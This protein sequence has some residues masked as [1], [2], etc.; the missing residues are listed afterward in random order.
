MSASNEASRNHYGAHQRLTEQDTG[1]KNTWTLPKLLLELGL[2]W[3]LKSTASRAELLGILVKSS[4]HFGIHV[5]WT[6]YIGP[7]LLRP[8]KGTIYTTL[9]ERCIEWIRDIE[10]IIARGRHREYLRRC[11][12]IVGGTGQPYSTMIDEVTVAHRRIARQVHLLWDPYAVPAFLKLSDPELR[13]ALNGHLPDDSQLWPQDEIVNM[14]PQ[15]FRELNTTYLSNANF[16]EGFKLFLSACVVS[17]FTPFVSHYLTASMLADIGWANMERSHRYDKCLDALEFMM[18]LAKWQI[19]HD[20]QGGKKNTWRMLRLAVLSFNDLHRV[21]GSA[22]KTLFSAVMERVSSNA[23]NMS[24]SCSMMD[25]AYAYVQ[26]DTSAGFFDSFLKVS[27]RAVHDFKK[28]MRKPEPTTLHAPGISS[29]YEYRILVAR[30]IIVPNFL[31]T[32]PL[33]DERR[34]M[35]LHAAVV[36]AVICRQITILARFVFYYGVDFLHDPMTPV[37]HDLRSLVNDLGRYEAMAN[38][39]GFLPD[40]TRCETRNLMVDG[41]AARLASSIPRVSE[42]E[43]AGAET[44]QAPERQTYCGIPVDQLFF[45][46]SCFTHCGAT[47]RSLKVQAGSDLVNFEHCRK[48]HDIEEKEQLKVVPRLT[49]SHVNP[50]KLEKMNVR[51]ATQLFSR[52]VA[53]GLKFYRE[54]QKPG[55]EGTEGTESFTRRMNDL[56]DALNAKC[57]AEGTRKNSPQLKVQKV[58]LRA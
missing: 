24:M 42:A 34:P 50:K 11:A 33:F 9:D 44:E 23:H 41:W 48:L 54:Q 16:T 18:P 6:F 28:L 13:R 1:R 36:G 53:V 14:Q 52:S 45:L 40:Q 3:S 29:I 12:E 47:G 8:Y 25:R 43:A 5:F 37:Y 55:F 38:A 15:L 27:S 32:P 56:F 20:T 51:L 58:C 7:H 49:A 39:N 46:A 30:E 35:S 4:L 17:V 26:I 57:P 31:T 22:F 10:L 19:E 2:P 21:Y